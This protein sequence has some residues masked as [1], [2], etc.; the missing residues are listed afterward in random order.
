MYEKIVILGVIVSMVF[1]ELTGF[2]AGLILPG[3]FALQL[4]S[5]F[6]AVSTLAVSVC[7]VLL[8]RLVSRYLIL[9]GRRRFAFLI[10][11]TFFL[12][13]GASRLGLLPFG[14]IGI[15]V[16][17]ILAREIDRQGIPATLLSLSVTTLL[18]VLLVIVSGGSLPGI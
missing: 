18:T 10:L 4:G 8:C 9:Y 5:P 3:Y 6:K 2:S 17:G 12:M 16:P 1:T 13:L 15:L 7:A 14:V 11:T